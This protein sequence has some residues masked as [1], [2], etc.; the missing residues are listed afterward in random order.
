MC[1]K[2]RKRQIFYFDIQT[3]ER[4]EIRNKRH[5]L[6]V[7]FDRLIFHENRTQRIENKFGTRD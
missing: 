4:K 5:K 7:E 2:G 1:K 6:A 3:T